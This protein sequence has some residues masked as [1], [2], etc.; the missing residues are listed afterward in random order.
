ML[1]FGNKIKSFRKIREFKHSAF[2]SCFLMTILYYVHNWIQISF[3]LGYED[4]RSLTSFNRSGMLWKLKNSVPRPV[5][6]LSLLPE[7]K[8]LH[9]H[10]QRFFC[11][12]NTCSSFKNIEY[13]SSICCLK[14]ECYKCQLNKSRPSDVWYWS[15]RLSVAD[16]TPKS[17][18]DLSK[19]DKPIKSCIDWF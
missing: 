14:L 12:I 7:K 13:T 17:R 16:M 1:I 5:T 11:S 10:Q 19:F 9:A 2:C 15:N 6:V 4:F 3:G 18:I 8:Y